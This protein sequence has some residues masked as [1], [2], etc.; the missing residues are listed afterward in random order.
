[1]PDS[2]LLEII[3]SEW[4]RHALVF[5]DGRDSDASDL[6]ELIGG[7]FAEYPGCVLELDAGDA[8]LL[9]IETAFRQWNGQFWVVEHEGRVRAC[10]GF[11]PS[12][13]AP[14]QGLELRKLYVHKSLRRKGIAG[15]LCACVERSARDRGMRFVEAWSDTR[16]ENAHALYKKRGYA[17]GPE[18]RALHDR[19]QTIEYYFRLD[20]LP[21]AIQSSA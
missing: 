20:L 7:V 8:P 9:G 1:M 3:P 6:I 17:Q 21:A 14:R 4:A 16:F 2:P 11:T 12:A 19:S 18:T 10:A 13:R 15:T 5:R